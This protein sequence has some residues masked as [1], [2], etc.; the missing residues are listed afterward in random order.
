MKKLK[1]WLIFAV[2][3]LFPV[4]A[5]ATDTPPQLDFMALFGAVATKNWN[6]VVTIGG[7]FGFLF[8]ERWL[9]RT[10][11]VGANSTLDLVIEIGRGALRGAADALRRQ[12]QGGGAAAEPAPTFP[13]GGQYSGGSASGPRE[14]E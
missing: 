6:A 14:G 10:T 5:L 7:A 1:V 4:A 11:R 13:T 8:F 9:G 2:L 3:A 12:G